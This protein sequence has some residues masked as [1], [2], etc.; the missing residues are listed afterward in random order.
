MDEQTDDSYHNK[1]IEEWLEA[2]GNSFRPISPIPSAGQHLQDISAFRSSRSPFQDDEEEEEAHEGSPHFKPITRRTFSK[3]CH[4]CDQ[5]YHY[6]GYKKHLTTERHKQNVKREQLKKTMEGWADPHFRAPYLGDMEAFK[7]DTEAHEQQRPTEILKAQHELQSLKPRKLPEFTFCEVC[8]REMLTKNFKPH[9]ETTR[10]KQLAEGLNYDKR[11]DLCA[12]DIKARN[13]EKHINTETHKKRERLLMLRAVQPAPPPEEKGR[14]KQKEKLEEM[15]PEVCEQIKSIEGVEIIDNFKNV[16]LYIT[17]MKEAKDIN[18][19]KEKLDEV[20]SKITDFHHKISISAKVEFYKGEEVVTH[21]IQMPMTAITSH[22]QMKEVLAWQ[23]KN[24]D[25]HIGERYFQGSGLSLHKILSCDLWLCRYKK[26]KGGHHIE[27][28]FKTPA[29]INVKSNDEKCF[30]WSLLAALYPPTNHRCEES[31]YRKYQHELKIDADFPICVQSDVPKIE[32]DNNLAINIFGLSSPSSPSAPK[33]TIKDCSLEPLYLSKRNAEVHE[34]NAE[35][36]ER[37]EVPERSEVHEVNLLYYKEHYMCLKDANAFYTT[38][39]GNKK[40]LCTSCMN[41]FCYKEALENHKKR[42]EEHDYCEIRLPS[43]EKASLHFKNG[44]F[45]NR[46]PFAVYADFE[47]I[48]EP[49]HQQLGNKTR[50]LIKQKAAAVGAYIHSDYPD[51]LKGYYWSRRTEDVVDVFC[52]FLVSLNNT[53]YKLLQTNIP[54]EMTE[55]DERNFRAA[56]DCYYCD[57]NLGGDRVRDHDHFTGKY[58]GPAHNQCNLNARKVN[59]VPVFFHNLSH[60]DAHLFIKQ[61]LNK[62]TPKQKQYFKVLPKTSEEYISFQFGCIRFL[63]SY[64]FLQGG[65]DAVTKS[66]ADED[67]KITKRFHPNEEDFK[68]L[69]K[70]GAVPYSFYTSHDSFKETTLTHEMFFDELKN[71]MEPEA[72]FLKAKETWDHFGCP[73]HGRFIDLYLKSDVLLLADLFE[74]FR[75]VNLK[76]FGIDPCHCYSAPGL[77]WQAGLKYTDINL[78]LLTDIDTLLAFEKGIRGGISGVMGTR[79]AAADEHHKLLYVDANNLYGWAMMQNQPYGSFERVEVTGKIEVED[80][81]AI[82][83]NSPWGYFFEVDLEYPEN[84]KSTSKN[85]P[86][87]PESLFIKD[88]ELSPYQIQLLEGEKR[89]RVEKLVLTQKTKLRYIVHYRLLQFYLQRGMIL[90]K[91]HSLISFK[92][93]KW[94]ESY[95]DFNTKRRMDATTDF[96]KDYFKLMNNAFYGKTCENIRNRTNV[97]LVTDAG[98][99]LKMHANP[100]FQA[101]NIFDQS[102]QAVIMRKTSI[103]FDKPIYIGTTVLELSKLLM[104]KFY[105]ETLQPYF[106]EK[107]LELL[108]Q[109]TDSFVLKIRTDDLQKDLMELKDHFDFSNY[110]KDHPLYD[111]SKKKVPGYFKDELAG[112]EMTEFIALRSKMYAYKTKDREEKRLKGIGK[113][114]VKKHITFDDYL[115]SLDNRKTFRHKMRTLRSEKHEMYIE[116]VEKKSLSPFDDKRYIMADGVT[117]YPFGLVTPGTR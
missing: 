61:L 84:I 23:L 15:D 116:E 37:S 5:D 9:L 4:A 95:I 93:R 56:A 73:D 40:H 94:L 21:G 103:L 18:E 39:D 28:P 82:S 26:T 20:L 75:A 92:Q 34:G 53:F 12:K 44:H 46:V 2:S 27:L 41:T 24:I 89:P 45:K 97:S 31:S 78:G 43:P 32:K 105:Y 76:Y 25:I 36:H 6:A 10:H 113:N 50:K 57:G 42:C 52:G 70:K 63:D 35:V 72:V 11:C 112:E 87:C 79:R 64:R 13:W 33:F 85:F 47:S 109:D 65:L 96:E 60:Y 66:M 106:G 7:R 14:R 3:Y 102:A 98:E 83:E 55:A 68:L 1:Q 86:F 17:M 69:R 74:R 51:L 71:E 104:Y 100:R 22:Q 49:H 77:T 110:P 115:D 114:V 54:L 88:D 38:G 107:N 8:Q 30:L 48:S 81:L 58:R 101:V 108:Y 99:A 67:F 19:Y 91:V 90:K 16:T 80:I 111:A 62:L 117:T 59:F 29:V